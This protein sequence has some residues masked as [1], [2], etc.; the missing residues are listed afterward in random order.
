MTY[1]TETEI[2]QLINRLTA[3]EKAQMVCG[4]GSM[5]TKG[6]ERLGIPEMTMADGP[7]GIRGESADDFTT[8]PCITS[9]ASSWDREIGRKMGQALG[10]ECKTHGIDMLLAPG[11][12][13]KRHILCGRNFEYFSEDPVLAGEMAA[14]YVNGLQETGTAACLKHFAVNNQEKYRAEISAEL[15]ERTLREIYLKAFEIVVKKSRPAAV[16]CAYNKVNAIWCSENEHLLTEI[17]REEWGYQGTVV[18]DWGA[19]QDTCRALMAGMDLQMPKNQDIMEEIREGLEKG[20][21]SQK[22]FDDAVKRVLRLVYM[23]KSGSADSVTF[24]RKRQHEDAMEIEAAGITLLKNENRILPLTQEKYR[25]VAVIGSYAVS[26]V[27]CGQGSAE[28]YSLPQSVDQPLEE[29]KKCMPRTEFV[30]VEGFNSRSYSDQMLWPKL[31]EIKEAAEQADAV[32]VF[33]G[34]M[35][36]EDTE[37]FD[38]RTARLNPNFGMFIEEACR[39]NPNV[40]V[41]LQ[42]GSAL[43]LDDWNQKTPAILEMWLG[44]EACGKAVAQ[45]LCGERNPSGKLAETFPCVERKDLNYPGNGRHIGYDEKLEIGYRY[46]D[47]HPEEIGYPFGHGLSYT[48]FDYKDLCVLV[49]EDRIGISFQIKNTG[50]FPGAEVVQIYVGN[51]GSTVSRPVKEL[52]AF[53]KI[54]LQT[55]ESK[56]VEL[57]IPLEEIGYYNVMLK[58]WVTE[59]GRYE[60]YVGSSSQDIRLK[61]GVYVKNVRD[62]YTQSLVSQ[63]QMIGDAHE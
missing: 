12:N 13:M 50:S 22:H 1:M 49:D 47:R 40:V 57:Q 8:F 27:R 39:H 14:G 5:N 46:Y 32:L 48:T 26:P 61:K 18:S 30:Y 53:D 28:V 38:R 23:A 16:M 2:D 36:S 34:T 54:F 35:V 51:P 25:K 4:S 15:D 37:M 58:K 9:V 44:G 31:G 60:I 56:S 52:K 43:I 62:V 63:G 10:M 55:G 59:S 3:D 6:V 45:I 29:L 42:S 7:C 19:V 41:V 33:A 11:I 21:L 24:D 20:Y 17:L